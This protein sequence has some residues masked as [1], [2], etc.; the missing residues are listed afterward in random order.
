MESQAERRFQKGGG[1]LAL[2][3]GWLIG[4]IAWALHQNVSYMVVPWVCATEN[5]LVLHVATL[6][7]LALA[8]VGAFIAWRNWQL[9][10]RGW[11]GPGG[12]TVSRSR[13][14]AV[15]GMLVSGISFVG[16]LVEAIPNFLIDACL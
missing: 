16:I 6:A 7:A 8:A 15:G 3:A 12:G 2:W 9:A 13:F 14:L 5:Y 11:P 1:V 4:P 10:G